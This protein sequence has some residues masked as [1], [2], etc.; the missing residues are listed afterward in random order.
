VLVV[1]VDFEL[2][3]IRLN[4][5]GYGLENGSS[6]VSPSVLVILPLLVFRFNE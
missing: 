4:V 6:S 1:S 2:L 5:F 3:T